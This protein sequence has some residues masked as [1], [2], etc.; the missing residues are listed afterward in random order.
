MPS[1]IKDACDELMHQWM[2]MVK[3]LV[4]SEDT[5]K[6]YLRRVLFVD[7]AMSSCLSG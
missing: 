7:I 2:N 4:D 6:L 1:D 5:I 3:N